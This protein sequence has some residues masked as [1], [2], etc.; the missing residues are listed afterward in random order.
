MPILS[1]VPDLR[2]GGAQT[3]SCSLQ[4][5]N[6]QHSACIWWVCSQSEESRRSHPQGKAHQHLPLSSS[7]GVASPTPYSLPD[8]FSSCLSFCESFDV[9]GCSLSLLRLASL[10]CTPAPFRI[11]FSDSAQICEILKGH[12]AWQGGRD[13]SFS[14]AML[15]G[16]VTAA[17][18]GREGQGSGS[19][20]GSKACRS[21]GKMSG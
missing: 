18:A 20:L 6:A 19:L 14:P 10:Q 16:K 13:C 3:L 7:W 8:T 9:C 4:H 21:E 2:A 12:D 11:I 5:R 1:L 15:G 17:W